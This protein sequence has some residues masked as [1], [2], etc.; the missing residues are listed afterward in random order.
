MVSVDARDRG[1]VSR[2]AA[3]GHL[4]SLRHFLARYGVGEAIHHLG[5][6]ASSRFTPFVWFNALALTPD[7]VRKGT[8]GQAG[9]FAGRMLDA[10]A[11][12]PY[13]R[14]PNA[15]VGDEFLTEAI[16]RGDRCYA[17]FDGNRLVSYS[18]YSTRAKPLWE[19]AP[20]LALY[21]DPSCAYM[22]NSYTDPQYRGRGLQRVGG[23]AALRAYVGQGLKGLVCYVESSNL[24]SLRACHRLGY[25][26]FGHFVTLRLG[27]RLVCLGTP[28]CRRY[29]LR[30]GPA[31]CAAPP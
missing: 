26:T 10:I 18:W 25:V 23:E 17:L 5:H 16:A 2:R 29:G 24:A 13:A 20:G 4:W 19:I 28:G 1:A 14:G 27:R 31:E 12:R 11:L 6:A 7:H 30:I 21:F 9:Q 3:G 8:E 15:L 22:Y